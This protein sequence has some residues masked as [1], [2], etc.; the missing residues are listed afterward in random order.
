MDWNSSLEVKNLEVSL[1][2]N[3]TFQMSFLSILFCR[4]Y[5]FSSFLFPP[6]LPHSLP[7]FLFRWQGLMYP[8]LILSL[9]CSRGWSLTPDLSSLY[10]ILKLQACS[11]MSSLWSSW[12]GTRDS[13]HARQVLYQPSCLCVMFSYRKLCCNLQAVCISCFS[14]SSDES[15][16]KK[17]KALL[18]LVVW[19]SWVMVGTT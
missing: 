10:H 14:P 7:S 6:S 15:P 8:R 1:D 2:V 19:E 9:L 4:L 16:E 13:V 11:T 18:W 12:E 17:H 5:L 3:L